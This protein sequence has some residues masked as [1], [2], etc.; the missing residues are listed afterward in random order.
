M[1]PT[2]N[3]VFFFSI[4]RANGSDN[5]TGHYFNISEGSVKTQTS[6]ATAASS[7]ASSSASLAA[8]SSTTPTSSESVVAQPTSPATITVVPLSRDG[9]PTGTTAGMI[10]GIFVGLLLLVGG[11]WWAWT[12]KKRRDIKSRAQPVD[13]TTCH[14]DD[15]TDQKS[16]GTT[17]QPDDCTDQQS[18]EADSNEIPHEADTSHLYELHDSV[19]R[20]IYELHEPNE[21]FCD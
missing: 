14:P 11:A 12:V 2:Y 1:D 5:F 4:A 13:G 20:P 19:K 6:S 10:V 3:K 15:C 7:A 21:E 8:T 9:M 17:R 18:Y 16:Y